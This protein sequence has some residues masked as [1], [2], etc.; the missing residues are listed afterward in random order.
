MVHDGAYVL[1]A[2]WSADG[3]ASV[4]VACMMSQPCTAAARSVAHGTA[5]APRLCPGLHVV[6][7]A[8]QQPPAAIIDELT[9][10]EV[11]KTWPGPS[12]EDWRLEVLLL[13]GLL[14]VPRRLCNQPIHTDLP[15]ARQPS[16]RA[17][18]LHR[19]ASP[20]PC[21]V[22]LLQIFIAGGEYYDWSSKL[23]VQ[24]EELFMLDVSFGALMRWQQVVK[25]SAG[26]SGGGGGSAGSSPGRTTVLFAAK[27]VKT[28]RK[29]VSNLVPVEESSKVAFVHQQVRHQAG[30]SAGDM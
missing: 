5:S 25:D 6:R 19:L 12:V 16:I 13:P 8:A 18:Q 26:G 17:R 10:W 30:R 24:A 29:V 1:A 22:R 2:E 20:R 7:A 27:D 21:A 9:N 15:A 11:W 3:P 4:P 14:P 28:R 23:W